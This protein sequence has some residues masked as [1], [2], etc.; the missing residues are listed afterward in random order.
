MARSDPEYAQLR[1]LVTTQAVPAKDG[2]AAE[3][4][5]ETRLTSIARLALA[6][7]LE[8]LVNVLRDSQPAYLQRAVAEAKTINETSFFRD[9][10]PFEAL[11]TSV[12]PRL[13]ARRRSV[14]RLRIWAAACS[15]GQE[16]YSLALLLLHGFSELADW[17]V[18]VIGTD[19]S[20]RAIERAAR[21]QYRPGEAERGLPDGLRRQYFQFDGLCWNVCPELR[22]LCEFQV[23]DLSAPLPEMPVFDLILLRNVLLYFPE[24]ER[25]RLFETAH[26][27]LSHDGFL[28]LG[29]V[30]QAED[31]TRLFEPEAGAVALFYRPATPE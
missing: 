5:F 23:M 14:R 3:S 8:G 30:E 1:E 21:G 7:N 2:R 15:T 4:L 6:A 28:M 16:A 24:Q 18:K 11:R 10:E 9:L 13:I 27:Q 26:R 29:D 17:D 20:G 22:A 12:L 19:L 31:S 25:P